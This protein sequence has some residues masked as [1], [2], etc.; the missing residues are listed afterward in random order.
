MNTVEHELAW[1]W[2]VY[3]NLPWLGFDAEFATS[4]L[5]VMAVDAEPALEV[6]WNR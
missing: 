3:E 2:D 4:L 6:A 1:A 5:A